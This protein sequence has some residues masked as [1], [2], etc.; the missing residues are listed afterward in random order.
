[1]TLS[2]RIIASE[3]EWL[4]WRQHDVTASEISAL[5]GDHPFLTRYGLWMLKAGKI[6]REPENEEMR[7]GRRLEKVALEMAFEDHP[8]WDYASPLADEKVYL[9]ETTLR[10]GATPDAILLSDS[11]LLLEIK[12]LSESTFKNRWI[13]GPPRHVLDQVLIG[14]TLSSVR[15]GVVAAMVITYSGRLRMHYFEVEDDQER[16]KRL[17]EEVKGF[18]QSI[19]DGIEPEPDFCSDLELIRKIPSTGGEIDLTGDNE[20]LELREKFDFHR[21]NESV[22]KKAMDEIK[23]KMLHKMRG[24]GSAVFN[25]RPIARVA[26]VTKKEH[27]VK[28]STYPMFKFVTEKGTKD[29]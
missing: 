27:V 10:L 28:A 3:S 1:M 6:E 2:R 17:I 21:M 25:S 18:W 16:I 12:T 22:S 8:E 13:D 19:A 14:M 5:T 7:R 24:A 23:A 26:T 29:E 11:S 15:K 20:V 9:S 4:S